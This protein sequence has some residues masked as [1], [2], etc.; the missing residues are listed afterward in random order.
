MQA[1]ISWPYCT[2][3]SRQ[4]SVGTEKLPSC[5]MSPQEYVHVAEVNIHSR[6]KAAIDAPSFVGSVLESVREVG[7]CSINLVDPSFIRTLLAK[8]YCR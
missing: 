3:W 4:L 2:R 6:V 5:L 1:N 8:G 7:N